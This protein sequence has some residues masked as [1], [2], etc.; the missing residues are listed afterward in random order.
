[1]N[2]SF[3]FKVYTSYTKLSLNASSQKCYFTHR[4][5]VIST[6]QSLRDSSPFNWGIL[7]ALL[8]QW[9]WS[10]IELYWQYC[11]P[12]VKSGKICFV[13]FF[14]HTSLHWSYHQHMGKCQ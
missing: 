14:W 1:V 12:Q 7:T 3:K 13:A 2:Y 8:L 11:P 6:Y 10:V 5:N 9:N 4:M